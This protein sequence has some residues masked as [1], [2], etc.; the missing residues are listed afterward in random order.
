MNSS[1]ATLSLARAAEMASVAAISVANSRLVRRAE[2][3][4][5]DAEISMASTMP[6]F[7]FL[8]EAF[9]E[10]A[11]HAIGHVPINVAHVVAGHVFAQLLQVHAA[12]AKL[13][14]MRR[15]SCR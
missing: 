3:N 1:N 7:A 5:D 14:Q 11:A 13:A 10:R 8:A 6:E 4:A 15:P 12:P 2:P 9:H